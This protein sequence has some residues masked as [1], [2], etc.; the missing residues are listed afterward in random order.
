[1]VVVPM[2]PVGVDPRAQHSRSDHHHEQAG[3]QVEPRVQVL[4]QDVLRQRERDEAER[5][6]AD[7]VGHGDRRAQGHGMARLAAGAHQVGGDHRLSVARRQR[8][9]RAP[10]ECR[11]QQQ[12]QHALTRGGVLED[13][14]E[15]VTAGPRGGGLAA[16]GARRHQGSG[17]GLHRE[18]GLAPVERAVEKVLRVAAQ[19]VGGVAAGRVRAHRRARAGRRHHRLPAHAVGE[20]VVGELHPPG[21]AHHGAQRLL[22][23]GRVEPRLPGWEAQSRLELA[24]LHAPPVDGEAQVATQLR[25]LALDQLRARQAL[26]LGGGDLRLVEHVEHVHAV[27]G[28]LDRAEVVDREVAQWMGHGA[29]REHAEAGQ[30]D[31]GPA[32]ARVSSQHLQCRAC[33]LCL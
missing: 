11:E 31:A 32:P 15:A 14:R 27:V 23:A 12:H 25:L 20:R 10:A 19:P 8:V 22:E 4:G 21:V 7:G 17:A 24:Q 13:P 16:L 2:P 30:A 3:D 29:R 1:M 9:K 6:H 18:G 33:F 5:E 28:D 26:L